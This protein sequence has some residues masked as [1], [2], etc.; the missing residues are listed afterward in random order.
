MLRGRE[1]VSEAE[2]R[3][4][5]R[6]KFERTE[7]RLVMSFESTQ[8]GIDLLVESPLVTSGF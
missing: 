8:G 5:D 2:A 3:K 6:D 1:E 4:G 7:R